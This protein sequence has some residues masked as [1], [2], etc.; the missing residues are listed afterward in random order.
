MFSNIYRKLYFWFLLVFILTIAV[1]SILIHSFYTERVRDELQGQLESHARFLLA[2]YEQA[3]S[4]HDSQSCQQFLNRVKQISPLR[5]WIMTV[6]G[7]VQLSNQEREQ[8]RFKGNELARA[9]EGEV[10]IAT[11]H[12]A[13]PYVL[14]PLRNADGKVDRLAVIERGFIRGSRFPRFPFFASL[15]VVLITIGVLIFPLSKRLTRPILELHRLGREW[16]EGRLEKRA[17]VRGKDEISELAGTFNTMA[18][19]LQRMLDQRKEFLASISHELK[20]PLARMRIA[21]ELLSERT[22][23]QTNTVSLIQ[24]IQ[25]EIAESEKLIEQLLVLS[26][27]EMNAP[28][29]KEPVQLEKVTAKA[30]QQVAPLA[31]RAGIDLICSGSAMIAGDLHQ[32]ERAMTNVLENAVKFSESPAQV[33]IRIASEKGSA[34][35]RCVDEGSGIAKEE[36]EKIFQPYYRGSRAAGKDGSGLGLFIA[37]R[38]VDMHGGTIYAESNESKGITIVMQFPLIAP[39]T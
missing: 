15:I 13:P 9:R 27:I 37:K 31:H 18:E 25:E 11:R 17:P 32:L 34:F 30:I 3:C 26:K 21:L 38:I 24:N 8:P 35:W 5:F 28:S 39:T 14:I 36:R 6:T 19:N 23:G 2:E 10:V 22:E 33:N 20:S 4:D 7:R 1:V 12:R 16:A 29:I